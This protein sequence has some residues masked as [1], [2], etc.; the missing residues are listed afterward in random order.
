MGTG[1]IGRSGS[2]GRG[3]P[4]WVPGLVFLAV[5]V[6]RWIGVAACVGIVPPDTIRIVARGAAVAVAVPA[7]AFMAAETFMAVKAAAMK[8]AA[9]MGLAAGH[10]GHCTEG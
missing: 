5:A 4:D 1:P 10:D 9:A 3:N 7:E 8:T 6:I 2:L